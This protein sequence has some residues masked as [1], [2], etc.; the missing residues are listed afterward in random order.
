MIVH[1]LEISGADCSRRHVHQTSPRTRSRLH[2]WIWGSFWGVVG[3]FMILVAIYCICYSSSRPDISRISQGNMKVPFES[4]L[5]VA[6]LSFQYL[7][8]SLLKI[9]TQ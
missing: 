2:E 7:V 4:E 5:G 3:G 9:F 8:L 6:C 1:D